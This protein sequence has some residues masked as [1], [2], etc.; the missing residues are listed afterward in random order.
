[1]YFRYSAE[2]SSQIRNTKDKQT[3]P[4]TAENVELPIFPSKAP[5]KQIFMKTICDEGPMYFFIFNLSWINSFIKYIHTWML[6][7]LP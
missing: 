6:R 7:Q 2:L 4:Q 3:R 1:M 5:K